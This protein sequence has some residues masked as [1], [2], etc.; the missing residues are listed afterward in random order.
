MSQKTWS[1][2]QIIN[3]L[4][5]TKSKSTLTR[6]EKKG[7][8]PKASR[9]K[10]GKTEYRFWETSEIPSIG[11]AIGS[12]KK[13][14][15]N[16]IISIYCPKGGVLKTTLAF[17]LSRMLAL[18]GITVCVIGLDVTKSITKNLNNNRK[19]LSNTI[20]PKN[21]SEIKNE[22]FGLYE[23]SL[24]QKNGGCKIEETLKE[25]DLPTLFYIPESSNLNRLEQKIREENKRE[26]A[27]LRL[28]KPIL[29]NF[30]VFIFDNSP[31]WN[32]LIQ[33]SLTMA[34]DVICPIACEAECYGSI[35]ENIQMIN[36]FKV[37]MELN[38]NNFVLVPTKVD[39][40]TSLSKEIEAKYRINFSSLIT[41]GSISTAI[42]GQ[43]SSLDKVSV[44]EDNYK[45]KLANDYFLVVSEIWER[46]NL[47][48]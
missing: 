26:H 14:N 1:A 4:Q 15:K 47:N 48:Q 35:I 19:N 6:E 32:F 31:S 11:Q 18:N 40:R 22:D 46:L 25:T 45:T 3:L 7:N 10:K 2:T 16:L 20:A 29:K 27:L 39:N 41:T 8:I 42:Q 28:I 38:W 36:D 43:E 21:I 13:P 5:S 17:N 33:N 34:T 37:N 23:A 12:L 30:D 9:V 44:I 24:G